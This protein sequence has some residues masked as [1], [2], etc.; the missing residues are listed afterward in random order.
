MLKATADGS[1]KQARLKSTNFYDEKVK[2][3]F[4]I[5]KAFFS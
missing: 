4:Q 1:T 5:I 3:I 2:R